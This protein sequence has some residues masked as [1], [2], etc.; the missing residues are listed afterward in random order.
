MK[1]T[2]YGAAGQ[3]TGSNFLLEIGNH[4]ILIDCGLN[5]GSNFSERHNFDPFPYNPKE[6][7]NVLVTHPHM[8]HIGLLPKLYKDGFRGKVY[9]TLPA[10]DFANLLLLDS[11]H[12]LIQEA[13]QFKKPYLYGVREVEELMT[14]WHGVEYHQ[15]I[16]I[17]DVKVTFYNAGHILGSSFILVEAEGKKIIFS[18]DLG[19][20][21]APIIGKRE[22]MPEG[23]DYCVMEATYGDRTHEPKEM[24]KE[25][26]EDAIEDA[27]RNKGV[28]MIPAFA[29]ERTQELLFDLNELAENGRIPRVPI[30]IDSPLAIKLT[31]V[32]KKYSQHFDKEAKLLIKKGDAIFNFPGLKMTMTAEESKAI[33]DVPAPKVI[34]AGA[35]MSNAGRILHHERRYLSDPNSILL[36]V[37]YQ[38]DG[39]LGRQIIDGAKTVKMFGEVISVRCRVMVARAFSAHADQPQL[40]SWIKPVRMNIKKIFLV[41]GEIDQAKALAQKIKDELAVHAE[42]AGLKQSVEL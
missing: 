20:S 8:D 36:I 3:V 1:L 18:G 9:S 30:F 12:I 14:H 24:R 13:E 15:V 28:L 39:S 2:F 42:P 21:P 40:L 34:I 10:K 35:G 27:V 29:M 16:P 23:V 7:T 17:G 41:H 4:K 6:I 38:A 33:N 31:E 11:E 32:Y 5:Q 26:L 25:I 19:N 22:E 37:G